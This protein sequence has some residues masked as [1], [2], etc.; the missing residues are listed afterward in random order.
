MKADIPEKISRTVKALPREK[1]EQVL[2]F[3]ESLSPRPRTLLEIVKEIEETI[4]DDVLAKLPLDGAEN[5][6]HYLYGAPKK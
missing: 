5:H 3:A 2:A 1:Q 4:P 6:D